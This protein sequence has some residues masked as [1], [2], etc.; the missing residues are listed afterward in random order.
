MTNRPRVALLLGAITIATL[1]AGCGSSGPTDRDQIAAIVKQEGSDPAT[2]C[3]RLTTGLLSRLGGHEG[4]M[5]QAASSSADSTTRAASVTVR[6][7]SATAVVV[8]RSGTRTIS[9]VKEK[10]GWKLAGVG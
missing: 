7:K 1:L 10:G 2:L 8:N 9:F 5:R 4:C 3:N 6:G